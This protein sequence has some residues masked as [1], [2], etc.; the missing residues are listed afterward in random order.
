MRWCCYRLYDSEYRG[1]TRTIPFAVN[2]VNDALVLIACVLEISNRGL[3]RL[4]AGGV[5]Q[6]KLTE[7]RCTLVDFFDPSAAIF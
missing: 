7:D 6:I 3:A 2:D 1:Y 5:V 4:D